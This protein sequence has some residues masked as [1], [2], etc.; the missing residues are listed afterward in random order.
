M[1]KWKERVLN[2]L[3]PRT[4]AG[5]RED[6]PFGKEGPLCGDCMSRLRPLKGP[7]G[8]PPPGLSLARAAFAYRAPIPALIHAFKYRSRSS[9]GEFLGDEMGAAWARHP[10]LGRPDALVPVPLH[11]SRE[12]F[13][14][15]N[16]ARILAQR[17]GR[18]T[19]LPVAELLVRK[20][21]SAP[22]ARR[23]RAER[24]GRLAGAFALAPGAWLDSARIVVIDD[25]WT[26]GE[27][28]SA[29]ARTLRSGGAED[30]RGFA[31]ARG[32]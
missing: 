23:T 12:R 9:V 16:Q 14:G 24:G 18:M 1:K 25:V 6:L 3:L 32:D 28:L 5:C 29:C 27:T 4:C 30:V 17:L 21:R 26:T 8:R 13:R 11:P 22:L 2:Y 19:G 20:R 10:G 15:F 7:S 31:L